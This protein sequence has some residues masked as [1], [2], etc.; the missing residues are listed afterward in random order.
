LAAALEVAWSTDPLPNN[1]LVVRDDIPK[2]IVSQV[3]ELLFSLHTHQQ[4]QQWLSRMEL[5]K[6]EQADNTTYDPVLK[7]LEKF[8][9]EV[10]P[11]DF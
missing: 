6:F 7:F 1:G 3:A 4:G 11:I 5:S 8:N 2:E 9:R 10:R